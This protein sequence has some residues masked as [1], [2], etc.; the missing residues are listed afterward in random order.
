M[1]FQTYT[2]R[3]VTMDRGC[4]RKIVCGCLAG[5]SLP[6]GGFSA[7]RIAAG[8][9]YH[10]FPLTLHPGERREVAGP[11]FY[12]QV[13]GSQRTVGMPPLW[14]RT[15]DP[16]LDYTETDFLYPLVTYDRFGGENRFQIL[17]LL[18]VS[19][20][21]N[22]EEGE[23]RRV[24][25]FPFYFQQRSTNAADNYTALLP[26]YGQLKKRLLRD[27][28]SVVLFPLYA[29]TRKRDVVTE[30]YLF[31]FF[32]RREGESLHGWQAWPFYGSET[33]E[34]H[35]RTNDFG[36][37]VPVPGHRK[38][39]ALWPFH[40]RSHTGIGTT[41][42]VRETAVL[43]LFSHYRSSNRDAS[44]YLWPFFLHA[45]DREKRYREWG[46]PWPL[47]GVARGE[48]KHMNRLWPL[49]SQASNATLRSEY[50]L[51]PL[52]KRNHA[53]AE[54]LESDRLRVL[55]FLYSD[56]TEKNTATGQARKRVD[57]WPLFTWKRTLEG[58]ERLQVLA[59]L[60]PLVPNNKSIERNWSPIWS[61]WR[62]ERDPGTGAASRSLLWNLWRRDTSATTQKSS[63]LF[64]LVQYESTPEGTRWKW[65]HFNPSRP[66]QPEPGVPPAPV[67]GTTPIRM[68]PVMP[69][70]GGQ[71]N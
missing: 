42:P 16:E 46:F 63:L 4:I 11:L 47:W 27:E 69:G 41:N 54:P 7:E 39:F 1:S 15:T 57:L 29:K 45:E 18:S 26:F 60:E 33:K 5:F 52:V 24:T 65:F 2:A 31:P 49:F 58:A 6:F 62:S 35:T 64:G 68:L 28:I 9:A 13:S 34:E 10:E 51:W 61:V 44:T 48:G 12:S 43:P 40:L 8:P 59:P 3:P 30:N 17:Q 20:G 22:Q 37:E 70:A 32:H 50:Y 56:S 19:G 36:D 66:D 21:R 55:F 67:I 23:T 53:L 14:T 71:P 25:V 38:S